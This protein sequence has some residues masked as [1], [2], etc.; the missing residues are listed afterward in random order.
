MKTGRG[1]N[2]KYIAMTARTIDSM[3]VMDT[4][5]GNSQS[6]VKGFHRGTKEVVFIGNK[7]STKKPKSSGVIDHPKLFLV[8]L[9]SLAILFA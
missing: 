1:V 7:L 4:K 5:N 2:D 3:V 8:L 9:C 6:L